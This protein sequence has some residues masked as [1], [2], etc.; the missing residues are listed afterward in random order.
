MNQEIENTATGGMDGLME[1]REM[2]RGM[3][4]WKKG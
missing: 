1:L 4:G 2:G 3:F